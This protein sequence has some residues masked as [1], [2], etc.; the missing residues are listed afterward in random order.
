MELKFCYQE[1]A[2]GFL[3]LATRTQS[4]ARFLMIHLNLVSLRLI[5]ENINVSFMWGVLCEC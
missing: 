2:T 4:I 3:F 1:P 5:A